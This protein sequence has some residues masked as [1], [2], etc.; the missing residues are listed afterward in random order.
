MCG[1]Y[2][3]IGFADPTE[4]EPNARKLSHRGPDGFGSYFDSGSLTYLAHCR[5]SIID[6]SERGAQPMSNE[7]GTLWL[8]FN[9]EIYNY[10][11]LRKELV[12]RGHVFKS[13]T[14][15]E[16]IIHAYEE[17]GI[18]CLE[19][20]NGMFALALW[21]Q[22]Q[23][24]LFLA[25]DRFG[26]KPIYFSQMGEK[27]VFAS[28]PKAMLDLPFYQKRI[29][30]PA[31]LCYMIYGYVAGADSIWEGIHRLMP[32]HYLVYEADTRQM[33]PGKYW[34]LPTEQRS[35]RLDEAIDRFEELLDESVKS[36]L[37]SDVPV[38][39]FLSGGV[40]S[41]CVASFAAKASPHINTYCIGFEGW[42][43]NES[44]I[45]RETA[46]L[47]GTTHL[48]EMVSVRNFESLAK[49]FEY[50]DEP[51]ADNSIFPTYLVSQFTRQTSTVALSGDGGDEQFGGYNWYGE[52][53]GSR[54]LKKLAYQLGPMFQLLGV[55]RTELGRRSN[56]LEQYRRFVCPSFTLEDLEALL[57]D[58]PQDL[59]PN[60]ET[61]LFSSYFKPGLGRYK[62]WQYIDAF[63]YLTE[64]NLMKV[65]RASM[66]HSL[67]V[68]VPL[69]DHRMAE[70][71]FSLQDDFCVRDGVKK[72]L[73]RQFLERKGV[74]HLVDRPKQG[75][76]CPVEFFWPWAQMAESVR[77]GEL[78]RSGFLDRKAVT[79]IL[80]DRGAYNWSVK[81]WV[82]AVLEKWYKIWVV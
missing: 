45:A 74:Q 13:Q 31:L 52:I 18:Q 34:E 22:K 50:F 29:H 77:E 79:K 33:K 53:E 60:D 23:R 51:L 17:W 43:R 9:G 30:F 41:S 59:M 25:R 76:G 24:R 15:S 69:L 11:A 48:E 42:D 55:G 67:E 38:G 12:G 32:G 4:L 57:P 82:L 14:D 3:V 49:V 1:I 36:C 8:T 78:V 68:R 40:D 66:A 47:M 37:L 27:F 73:L 46:Q 64:N 61:F 71:A 20:F 19:L 54:L 72:Y 39:V 58:L 44:A 56:H 62:R 26:I 63:T 10:K 81:C 80:E 21:D 6:L 65:D 7:D 5:L 75:F 28:E 2:G 16:V 35:W 70:F